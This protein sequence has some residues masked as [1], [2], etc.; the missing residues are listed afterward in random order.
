LTISCGGVQSKDKSCDMI[1]IKSYCDLG[2]SVSSNT[3]KQSS[4]NRGVTQTI[5][6]FIK[7]IQNDK[8][9]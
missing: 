7:N 6:P 9:L 3:A 5:Q 4:E 8:N 2:R 1:N